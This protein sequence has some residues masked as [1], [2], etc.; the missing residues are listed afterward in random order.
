M[1][2]N[3]DKDNLGKVLFI[4]G[5]LFF[6]SMFIT[7]LNHLIMHVDEYFTLMMMSF[8][9]QDII[10]I[11]IND[12]HPPLYYLI[13]KAAVYV[14][15]GLNI[16]YDAL[17]VIK[18][19][20]T[21]P[22]ALILLFSLTELKSE[23]GWLTAGL[24]ALTMAC[25]CEFF[26]FF[27]IARMYSFGLLF[28][29]ASFYSYKKILES[30]D[31]KYWIALTVFSVLGAYTHYFV[32]L[33]SVVLYVMLFIFTVKNKQSV[34]KFF[35][36]VILAVILYLPWVLTLLSQMLHVKKSFWVAQLTLNDFIHCFSF[37]ATFKGNLLIEIVAILALAFFIIVLLTR[38][39]DIGDCDNYWLLS[40]F[41]IFI[42]TILVGTIL[43]VTYKPILITRYLI[44]S[45]GI[46][47]LSISVLISKIEDKR[48]LLISAV[49]ILILC[50]SGV[51]DIII[52]DENMIHR[53]NEYDDVLSSVNDDAD[54]IIINIEHGLIE[55]A[56]YLKDVDIYTVEFEN[57]Y[58]VD[59]AKVHKIYNYK[60]MNSTEIRDLIKSNDD[61]SIYFLDCGGEEKLNDINKT[62]AGKLKS[63][64]VFYKID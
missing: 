22:Y 51:N 3:I 32:A 31:N 2:L 5:V 55:F 59:N 9:P 64:I 16:H 28:L 8:S 15:N 25:M 40:G 52:S 13:L 12:V 24:F 41:S 49:L 53:G 1:N 36:S 6:I 58:G 33:S 14:L 35:S 11:N 21:I 4:I 29:L 57:I 37:F 60:E 26:H 34:K 19:I 27:L 56:D 42:G 62:Q 23:Y 54:I 63:D 50:I 45:A 18:I 17:F 46:V 10:T 39:K 7:P 44:P 47:W 30:S 20:S 38:Y 48:I 43:S 61:K